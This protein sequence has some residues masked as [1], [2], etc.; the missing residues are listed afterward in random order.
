MNTQARQIAIK[1]KAKNRRIEQKRTK[2][3]KVQRARKFTIVNFVTIVKKLV[4][5]NF[6]WESFPY[7]VSHT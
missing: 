4:A 7:L 6:R 1:T 2:I 5:V 3:G